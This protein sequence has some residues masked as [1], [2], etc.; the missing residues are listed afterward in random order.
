MNPQYWQPIAATIGAI[1]ALIAGLYGIVTIPLLRT[2]KAEI[3]TCKAEIGTSEAR[4]KL[5]MT[6]MESRLSQ[7]I[8]DKVAEHGDRITRLEERRFIG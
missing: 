5:Q 7:R 1:A 3:G 2:I 6:E 8:S 4:L